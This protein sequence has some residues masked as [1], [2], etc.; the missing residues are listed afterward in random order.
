MSGV[1]IKALD[2]KCKFSKKNHENGTQFN[3]RQ[4]SNASLPSTKVCY[5]LVPIKGHIAY[6][7]VLDLTKK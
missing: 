5:S 1:E 7:L 3:R 4:N 6:L 2:Q